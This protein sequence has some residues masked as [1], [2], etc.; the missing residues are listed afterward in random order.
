MAYSFHASIGV[1][2]G[3]L[4]PSRPAPSVAACMRGAR[5]D[6][7]TA[8]RRPRCERHRRA[9]SGF[10]Q[11]QPRRENY[12]ISPHQKLPVVLPSEADRRR[13]SALMLLEIVF[14]VEPRSGALR[15][16]GQIHSGLVS[17][18]GAAPL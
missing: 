13:P 3:A 11:Q 17:L 18:F 16:T 4:Y 9:V 12:P 6:N 8:S 14:E 7:R 1:I 10:G 5:S 2:C 15:P